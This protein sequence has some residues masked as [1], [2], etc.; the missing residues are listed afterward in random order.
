MASSQDYHHFLKM[1]W[2]HLR[3]LHADLRMRP[4]DS[5]ADRLTFSLASQPLNSGR[6]EFIPNLFISHTLNRDN[7]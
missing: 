6:G 7:V 4:H 5:G 2:C 1:R 3:N